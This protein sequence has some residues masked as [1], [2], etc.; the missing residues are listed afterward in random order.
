MRSL[1]MKFFFILNLF[2][3]SCNDQYLRGNVKNSNDGKTYFGFLDDNGGA[4]KPLYFD[5]IVW[6]KKI[7]EV[8]LTNPGLHSVGCGDHKVLISFEI[9]KAVVFHFDYWGP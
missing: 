4:C 7:G 8:V 5:K 6:K 2:L 1:N 9:P 3:F